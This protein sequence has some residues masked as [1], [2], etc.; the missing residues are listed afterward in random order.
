MENRADPAASSR[1]AADPDA[2]A[3]RSF[4]V[5]AAALVIGALTMLVPLAS[6]IVMFLDPLR[7]RTR[8]KLVR[9]ATLDAVPDDGKPHLFQVVSDRDDAWN[10]YPQE[11]IGMVYLVRHPGEPKPLALTA[12]CPHLGCTVGYMPGDTMFRCPCHSSTFRFDGTRVDGE[13][14]VSPRDM[15]SLNVELRGAGS[16]TQVE[17]MFERFQAGR[18]EKIPVA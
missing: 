16:M 12:T 7:R 14:S 17:V 11:P 2:A 9:V 8:G 1:S 18:P 6:G 4:L 3:R 15:D 5:R 13:Q 10:H